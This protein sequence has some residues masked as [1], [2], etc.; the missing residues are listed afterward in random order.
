MTK[1]YGSR[2]PIPEGANPETYVPPIGSP[3]WYQYIQDERE[4]Y[5]DFKQR[6]DRQHR[7]I[8]NTQIVVGAAGGLSGLL[9]GAGGAGAVGGGAVGGGGSLAPITTTATAMPGG[10]PAIAGAGFSGS[11]PIPA[12]ASM[13]SMPSVGAS[14]GVASGG[15]SFFEKLLGQFK[16]GGGGFGGGGMKGSNQRGYQPMPFVRSQPSGVLTTGPAQPQREKTM[17]I[18]AALLRAQNG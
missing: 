2:R 16:N 4:A 15:T 11:G 18:L 9:S 14:S 13:P 8:R 1:G 10:I 7:H 3:E 6:L 5:E 12:M 17:E